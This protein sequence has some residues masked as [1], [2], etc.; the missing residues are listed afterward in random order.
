MLR[1]ALGLAAVS[2]VAM[3]WAGAA[4]ASGFSLKEQS[5]KE[6]GRAFAGG[7]AAADDASI[8]FYNPAGMTK[9]ERSQVS[10]N[11]HIL[12]VDS[13]QR[14]NGSTLSVPGAPATVPV[15]GSDGGNPF[16]QPVIVP[17]GYAAFRAS[18]RLWFGLGI[19][20]PFGLKVEYD[21]SFFGRY[22]SIK[23]EVKTVNIQPSVGYAI[24]DN[25]SIGG[26]IDIQQ[27]DVKLR[28]ALP[29]LVPGAGDG[30]V[31]ISGDDLSV[32]WN[33]GVLFS[34]GKARLGAHYRSK[35][36]HRLDG[37]YQVTG[38]V[39]PLASGNTSSFATA[40]LEI[41]E[42]VTLSAMYGV[43]DRVRVMATG[44]WFNWSRFDA[45]NVEPLG[46]PTVVSEQN[47]KDS[48]SGHGAVE[49]DATDRLTLRAG[50]LYDT[51]PTQDAFRTTRVPDGDRTW[52]TGGATW[53]L[54]DRIDVNVSYAHVFVSEEELDR[55][56]VLFAGTAAARTARTVST[57]SGNADVIGTSL[58]IRL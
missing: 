39:G 19:S 29:N 38:L 41:P 5:A 17:T 48:W 13:Q 9:L 11:S 20:A 47:Y 14:N 12:F 51:T 24:N 23:S 45:I 43:G 3:G 4:H 2:T 46:R 50:G 10:L 28:N 56:D 1:K 33:A 16:D 58:T 53:R 36:V 55:S 37:Q 8:I 49:F 22:D 30:E 27:I 42:S 57:N 40:P 32:G 34:L 18:D 25:V 26:G 35:V 7:A 54:N 52:V 6:T 15:T 44:Q 31:N 21:P